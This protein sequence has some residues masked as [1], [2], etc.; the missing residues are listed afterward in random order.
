MS[1]L[2]VTSVPRSS[3]PG[4]EVSESRV[5][6]HW[7]RLIKVVWGD[8]GTQ[9]TTRNRPMLW[10]SLPSE[11]NFVERA[12]DPLFS[13]PPRGASSGNAVPPAQTLSSSRNPRRRPIQRCPWGWCTGCCLKRSSWPGAVWSPWLS[14]VPAL[15]IKQTRRHVLQFLLKN[16]LFEAQGNYKSN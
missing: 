12:E 2:S 4:K 9:N 3:K 10:L 11:E 1:V 16:M 13:Y 6:I 8:W 7:K 15:E 5:D 14:P